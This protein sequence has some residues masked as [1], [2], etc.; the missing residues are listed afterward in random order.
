MMKKILF[1]ENLNHPKVKMIKVF[2]GDI[3]AYSE[4]FSIS[5]AH[6]PAMSTQ[7]SVRAWQIPQALAGQ[8]REQ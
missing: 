4:G 5:S 3:N 8:E 1:L 7:E 6:C 2:P